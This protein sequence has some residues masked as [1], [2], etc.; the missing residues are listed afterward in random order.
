MRQIA[1]I[2]GQGRNMGIIKLVIR[3]DASTGT[4]RMSL[5]VAAVAVGFLSFA[6]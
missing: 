6:H 5:L 4:L 1:W 3:T 2:F